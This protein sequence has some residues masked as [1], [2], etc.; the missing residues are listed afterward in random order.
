[1]QKD[2]QADASGTPEHPLNYTDRDL[3][4]IHRFLAS[5]L[6]KAEN[7]LARETPETA[8]GKRHPLA[9]ARMTYW[10]NVASAMKWAGYLATCRQ[11]HLTESDNPDIERAIAKWTA[12]PLECS[13]PE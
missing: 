6:C 3:A 2:T 13:Q 7:S 4:M 1:M 5:C 10:R 12:I 9:I 11:W 8:E